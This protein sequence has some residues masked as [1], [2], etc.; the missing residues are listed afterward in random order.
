MRPILFSIGPFA[1]HSY[2]VMLLLAV[3]VGI[4]VFVHEA[5]RTGR[6]T[7]VTLRVAVG[8]LVGGVLGAKLSMLVFLGP[9][10][11]LQALPVLWFSGAS[12]SGALVGGYMGVIIA[13]RLSNVRRCTGD[14]LAPAIP[15]AHAIGRVGNFLA[16]DILGTPTRLAWGVYADGAYRHP[17]VLYEAVLDLA[18]F[19]LLWKWRRRVR[20]DGDLWRIYTVGYAAIRFPLEFLRVQ[21]TPLYFLGLTLVQWL[22]ILAILAFGYQVVLTAR[23]LNCVCD[24]LPGRKPAG[25]RV[26]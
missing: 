23:G 26:G 2:T 19:A 10:G 6:D 21:N 14:L 17:V 8:A 24:L 13:E 16:G 9:Q 1:V 11:F 4:A 12:F 22:C 20:N 25:S 15:L 18:L 5:R 7:E 3:A